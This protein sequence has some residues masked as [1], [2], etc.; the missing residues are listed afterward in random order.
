M[1]EIPS[2]C[3]SLTRPEVVRNVCRQRA[4]KGISLPFGPSDRF[5]EL[6]LPMER[7]I[8]LMIIWQSTCFYLGS[9]GDSQSAA[10]AIPRFLR[11]RRPQGEGDG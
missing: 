9:V 7:Y 3:S 10:K 1:R 5:F 4:I 11:S 6:L 2:I 8:T